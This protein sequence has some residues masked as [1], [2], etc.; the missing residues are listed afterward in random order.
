MKL[1]ADFH[2]AD[3]FESHQ[4][5]FGDRF[6]WDVYAP[7]GMAWFDAWFW[8]FE[9]HAHGDA[10]ARQ[11]LLGIWGGAEP[12]A[13]GVV[14]VPDSRHPGRTL[15]GLTL[16]AAKAM[17]LDIVMSTVPS[18]ANGFKN[19]AAQTGAR[20][21]V[22]VGNQWGDE[23]WHETPDAAILTTTSVVPPGIP[24]VVVHQEFSMQDFRYEPPAGFGPIRSFV[25]AFPET[26]EYQHFRETAQAG[27]EFDWQVYGAVGTAS[28]DEY[29]AGELHGTPEVGDAMRG[30]GAVWHAKHWSDGFGHVIHNAFAVGRPVF[31]YE[32]YYKDK[33]AGPLWV[34][35]VTSFD[36]E[37]HGREETFNQL[38]RLRA[39]PD[40]RLSM[41]EA[42]A[43]RFREVVDFAEDADKIADLVGLAVPA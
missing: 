7:Y 8:N 33:L 17:D 38:R 31:G 21:F 30:A 28:P 29:T 19:L 10:V 26:P 11:Y 5:V 12:D 4:L 3:L 43:A 23:A 16:E 37:R 42:A 1:L 40:R 18:N 24:H 32:S 2:H 22:H 39:D 36:V 27:P 20:W 14:R 25:N 9:R 34:D 41:C 15:T 6:G 35:G 13:N